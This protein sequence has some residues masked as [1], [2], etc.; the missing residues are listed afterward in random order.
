MERGSCMDACP[1]LGCCISSDGVLLIG[2]EKAIPLE[3]QRGVGLQADLSTKSLC[4]CFSGGDW[5]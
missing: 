4:D 5:L 3:A 1:L 2:F